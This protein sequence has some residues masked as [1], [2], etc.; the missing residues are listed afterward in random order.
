MTPFTKTASRWI[1][2]LLS[3]QPNRVRSKARHLETAPLVDTPQLLATVLVGAAGPGGRK[4]AHVLAPRRRQRQRR[5]AA[6]D[7]LAQRR[8]R[9]AERVEREVLAVAIAVAAPEREDGKG[10]D[11]EERKGNGGGDDEYLR[12]FPSVAGG[13]WLMGTR[14]RSPRTLTPESAA[15]MMAMME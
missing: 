10:G 6:R 2:H 14:G 3:T 7:A 12:V 4:A 1:K 9:R 11:E 15:P 5:Q 13:G 8:R